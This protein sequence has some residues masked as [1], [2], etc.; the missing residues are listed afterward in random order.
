[1]QHTRLIMIYNS[2][3][4]I[5]NLLV[6]QFNRVRRVFKLFYGIFGNHYHL[7]LY[8]SFGSFNTGSTGSQTPFFSTR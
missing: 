1:M 7:S 5:C 6:P 4:T 8:I 3:S 2:L